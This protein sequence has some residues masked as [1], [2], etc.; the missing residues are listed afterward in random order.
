MSALPAGCEPSC[1]A[2]QHRSLTPVE[3]AA[4]KHEHLSRAL[5]PWADRLR[6]LAPA[7]LGL[8]YRERAT[9]NARWDAAAGWRFGLV[10][11]RDRRD[12]FIAI[13]R[14]PVHAPQ[15]NAA[16]A[17]LAAALP[18][19]ADLPLA[20][21]V[22]S[23][24][25]LT[26]VVKARRASN[27]AAS[28]WV[29]RV[30]PAL[31]ALGYEGLWLHLHPAAGRRLFARAGWTLLWGQ[32]RSRDASGARHGPTAFAQLQPALHAA[33]LDAIDAHLGP[34]PDATL[35]DLYCGIGKGLTRATRVGAAAVGVELSG[36]AVECA[37]VNAPGAA[38][39]RGT[40]AQRL[41]QLDAW[42]AARPGARR[43]LAVNPP[44]SGL[45]PEVRDWIARLA[46]ARMSYLSCSA[47][48][49]SRDLRELEGCGLR[50]WALQPYDFFPQTHHVEVLALLGVGSAA[51][52]RS[53]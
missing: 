36:E 31:A 42:L 13:P 53:L 29:A 45:E 51:P 48:S 20:F 27:D 19:A 16:L 5:A 14:C 10:R 32:P 38:V 39:L 28:G 12:E 47:G 18:A 7:P 33:A 49:L 21:V 30:A 6:P 24:R 25:Q 22:A 34:G 26:L 11:H 2:C 44:R 41:P 37:T 17:A 43:L 3:S 52:H 23:G 40:C 35:V 50:V 8:G 15:L 9:L 1:H 4:R 46:P